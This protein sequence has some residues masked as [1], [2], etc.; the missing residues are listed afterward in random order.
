MFLFTFVIINI[1]VFVYSVN[2]NIYEIYDKIYTKIYIINYAVYTINK[3]ID[4]IKKQCYFLNM[5]IKNDNLE[6][7]I[8][9][10]AAASG[11]SMADIA[12]GVGDSPQAFNN[13]L[14]SEKMQK[15]IDY[16]QK[17]ANVC[18]Y[19]FVWDFKKQ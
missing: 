9:V 1:H 7:S 14:K 18:G 6:K 13:K 19:D 10:M 11:L 8:K 5:E 4:T 17:I 15:D 16:L 2:E 12:R 3:N